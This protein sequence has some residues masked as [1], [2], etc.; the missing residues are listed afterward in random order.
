M[1]SCTKTSGLFEGIS[2]FSMRDVETTFDRTTTS[3]STTTTE[4]TKVPCYNFV[5]H[6]ISSTWAGLSL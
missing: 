3:T 1:V 5:H 2:R 6:A 4:V